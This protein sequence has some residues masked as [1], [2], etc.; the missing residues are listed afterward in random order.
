[1]ILETKII[2]I[3]RTS[4]RQKKTKRISIC[5][6][7]T[8]HK[9][10]DVV[11]K[12]NRFKHTHTFCSKVC[13]HQ[14]RKPGGV[15]RDA[16]VKDI[17]KRMNIWQDSVKRT[18]QFRYGVQNSF[19]LEKTRHNCNSIESHTK[20]HATMKRNGSYRKSKPEDELY[21]KLCAEHDTENVQRQVPVTGTRWL[22][23]FYVKSIDTYIQF[24]GVYWHGLDRP[25]EEIAKHRTKRDVQIHK[26]WLTDR[27]QDEHFKSRGLRLIRITDAK[28]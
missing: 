25:I 20:R 6:C 24:D 2:S 14:S 4:C 16:Y 8:C 7:D 5:K 18:I 19:Q 27:E 12:T 1:M 26:K 15:A 22:I 9:Q 23:D 21:E 10:Y 17:H 3:N 13:R 11:F 28:S